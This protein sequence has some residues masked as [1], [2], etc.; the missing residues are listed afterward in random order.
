MPWDLLIRGGEVVTPDGV[1]RLDVASRAA[2][3]VEL[4]PELPGDAR[5][6]STRGPARVPRRDRPHVHFNEPGRTDWEGFATGSSP[7]PPGAAVLLRHA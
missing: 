3:I 5:E 2:P 7:S 6:T 1:R 4:A